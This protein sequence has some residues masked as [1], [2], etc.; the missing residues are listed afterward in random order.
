M[1]H[2][3]DGFPA[4]PVKYLWSGISMVMV[5]VVFPFYAWRHG[6]NKADASPTEVNVQQLRTFQGR[7]QLAA[8]LATGLATGLAF[9]L[10]DG[11][12]PI[13]ASGL[14]PRDPLRNDVLVWLVF[15]LVFGL[16]AGLA[17]R[18]VLG[19]VFAGN[20]WLRYVIAITLAACARIQPWRFGRFLT[21]CYQAGI[22]RETGNAY[23]FRHLELLHWLQARPLHDQSVA[24]RSVELGP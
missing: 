14:N 1:R 2:Y 19:L 4:L 15:G 13:G 17:T 12:Q 18:L 22:L 6:N 7:R 11:L 16:A 10:M 9:G 20:A 5:L 21:W 3:L 24:C 23:Q 8:S